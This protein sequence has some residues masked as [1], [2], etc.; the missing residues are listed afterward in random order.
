MD[1]LSVGYD[2]K[3]HQIT[4]VLSPSNKFTE[5]FYHMFTNEITFKI[6]IINIQCIKL[7]HH[8]SLKYM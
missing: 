6:V 4:H 1:V 3:L 5:V 2:K 7:G 8:I